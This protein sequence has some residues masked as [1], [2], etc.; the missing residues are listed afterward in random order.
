MNAECLPR[1]RKWSCL[2]KK[3]SLSEN[4]CGHMVLYCACVPDQLE[5]GAILFTHTTDKTFVAHHKPLPAIVCF[6]CIWQMLFYYQPLGDSGI[7]QSLFTRILQKR[8]EDY[9]MCCTLVINLR[10]ENGTILLNKKFT[11][12]QLMQLHFS[13]VCLLR[14]HIHNCNSCHCATAIRRVCIV[15]C[16]WWACCNRR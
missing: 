9:V 13:I 14:W 7:L 2:C 11:S 5:K 6:S 12:I 4:V 8:P 15:T 1:H 3:R 16:H 10:I